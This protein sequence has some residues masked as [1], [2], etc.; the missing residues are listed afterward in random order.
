[1]HA[2]ARHTY[3]SFFSTSMLSFNVVSLSDA[4][5]IHTV[6]CMLPPDVAAMLEGPACAFRSRCLVVSGCASSPRFQ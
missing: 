1:M 3:Q 4:S 5:S 2:V 6:S